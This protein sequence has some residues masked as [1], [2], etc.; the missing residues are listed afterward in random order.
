MHRF[1]V[2][3]SDIDMERNQF[4]RW[5][6][7]L[8][9]PDWRQRARF[10]DR[11]QALLDRIPPIERDVITLYFYMGKTQE[12][13]SRLLGI[14]QQAVSHRMYS[15]FRR[16]V[17]MLEQPE[18]R[19]D[20][21]RADL[22]VVLKDPLV[23]DI[24][25]FF[26]RTSSQTQTARK[27]GIT[28]QRVNWYLTSGLIALQDAATVDGLFYSVYFSTLMNHRN[29]LRDMGRRS[30]DDAASSDTPRGSA[31]RTADAGV[32]AELTAG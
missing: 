32:G 5:G 12:S 18:I 21:M 2:S 29:I 8:R 23:V 14:S 17:F 16:I 10:L 15:A 13:I 1:L 22:S 7:L 6:Q 25:C 4:R 27:F 30:T 9:D 11:L 19:P 26:A 20:Q 24:F 28:Q 3:L 31:L